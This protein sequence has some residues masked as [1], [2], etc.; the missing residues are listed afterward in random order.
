MSQNPT[1]GVVRV[2]VAIELPPPVITA[3]TAVQQQLAARAL[4]LRLSAPAGLHL[5]LAFIG[6]IPAGQVPALAGAVQQGTAGTGPFQLRAEGLGMFPNA[7]APRVIWAGVEGAPDA[8]A[9]LTAL[10]EGIATQL[11]GAGFTLDRRFDPHLT[12]ARVRDRCTPTERAEIGAAVQALPGLAPVLFDV[13]GVS[14]MRSDMRP[15]GAV[16]SRLAHVVL[17]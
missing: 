7:R 13:T 3:L 12:L 14:V 5:T 1:A 2:F 8:M 10:R 6:E 4:P 11:R 9:A 15:S 16:Y 17:A